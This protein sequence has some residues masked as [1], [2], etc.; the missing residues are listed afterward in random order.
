[1][2]PVTGF[3][4]AQHTL[5]QIVGLIDAITARREEKR[6][7]KALRRQNERRFLHDF[8]HV[9]APTEDEEAQEEQTI[10]SRCKKLQAVIKNH[11]Q[12]IMDRGPHSAQAGHASIANAMFHIACMPGLPVTPTT[13]TVVAG[14]CRFDPKL[15][16]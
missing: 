12:F 11:W 3:L 4:A 1:M 2:D 8:S 14:T 15:I 10:R 5:S 9:F 16:M 7:Q 13:P 6:R